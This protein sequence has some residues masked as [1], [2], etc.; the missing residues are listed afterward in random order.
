VGFS[1]FKS[2]T[3]TDEKLCKELSEIEEV[4]D[5]CAK[6]VPLLRSTRLLEVTERADL[7]TYIEEF[8]NRFSKNTKKGSDS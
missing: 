5:C 7:M 6:I 8:G 4:W 2:L 3:T 1:T